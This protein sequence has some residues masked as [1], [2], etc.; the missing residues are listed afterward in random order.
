MSMFYSCILQKPLHPGVDEKFMIK[1]PSPRNPMLSGCAGAGICKWDRERR[2]NY[3]FAL[4]DRSSVEL[5]TQGRFLLKTKDQSIILDP[6]D[7]FLLRWQ[8]EFEL[9]ALTESEKKV[10]LLDRFSNSMHLLSV[11]FGKDSVIS[12][13]PLH[14]I[15]PD[16]DKVIDAVF[17][18]EKQDTIDPLLFSLLCALNRE[19]S[20]GLPTPVERVL[21]L[22]EHDPGNAVSRTELV[23]EAG[24]SISTLNRLFLRYFNCSPCEYSKQIRMEYAKQMLNHAGVKETAA[25]CGYSSVSFFCK[26]FKNRFKVSPGKYAAG[27]PKL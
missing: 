22:I 14:K 15:E 11:L 7:L 13:I 8:S 23:R 2:T 27:L 26:D 19:K 16:F 20:S 6:G 4:G 17:D 12:G 5:I 18:S 24:V 10:I 1:Y 25:A 9:Q 3:S 21:A